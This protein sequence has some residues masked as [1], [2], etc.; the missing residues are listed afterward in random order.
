MPHGERAQRNFLTS[1]TGKVAGLIRV[2]HW[3]TSSLKP[4]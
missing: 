2:Y 1:G 3:E 4:P